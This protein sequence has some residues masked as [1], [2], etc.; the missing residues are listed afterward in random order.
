MKTIPEIRERVAQIGR[1]LR[2]GVAPDLGLELMELAEA[3]KRRSPIRRAKRRM[4]LTDADMCKVETYA[5]G[6]SDASYHEI[7]IACGVN[8]GRVSEILAG[9]RTEDPF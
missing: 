7:G 8:A 6:H 1:G 5:A 2:G 4:S 3:M 9:K